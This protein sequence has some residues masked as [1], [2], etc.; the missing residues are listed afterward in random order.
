MLDFSGVGEKLKR[1]EENIFNLHGEITDFFEK[2]DYSVMPKDDGELFREAFKYHKNRVIPSRFSVL[3]GEIVHHLRSCFDHIVWHFSVLPVK[4]IKKIEF[5]VFDE[6][7]INHDGRLLFER[8]IAG[9]AD[10]N[11][12][13]MIK[14]LQPYNAPDPLND[15]LWVIHDFDIIDKHRELV[16]SFATGTV[17]FPVAMKPI[18]EAYEKAHPELNRV[19]VARHFQNHGTLMPYISFRDFGMRELQPVIPGLVNLFNYTVDAVNGFRAL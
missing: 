10:A 8:K 7:P 14:G 2:G 5:P 16:V 4:N 11:V 9:I 17:L 6:A 1:A 18:L 19:Q 3:A 13:A 12:V 15:P